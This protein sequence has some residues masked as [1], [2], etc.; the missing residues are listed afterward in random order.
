MLP[1]VLPVVE[2]SVGGVVPSVTV[3]SLGGGTAVVS[4]LAIVEPVPEALVSVGG[5]SGGG[6]A[7]DGSVVVGVAEDVSVGAGDW[8]ALASGCA[9]TWLS[10]GAALALLPSTVGA[11][12]VLSEI[13][14]SVVAGAVL[15]LLSEPVPSVVGGAVLPLA[16]PAGAICAAELEAVA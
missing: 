6:V 14:L 12:P 5:L 3:E 15:P 7:W 10:V 4:E 11:L 13:V 2:P 8:T 16:S 9:A 1:S